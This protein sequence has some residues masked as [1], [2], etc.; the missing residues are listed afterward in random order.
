MN[1]KHKPLDRIWEKI[2]KSS[3]CWLWKAGKNQNGYGLIRANGKERLAHR[4]AWE[5]TN[6]PIPKGMCICHKC[7]NPAC[8]NPNHL[9]LGTQKDNIKDMDGKGRRGTNGVYGERVNTT[10]LTNNAV[11]EIRALHKNGHSCQCLSERFGVSHTQ[12]WRIVSGHQWKSIL[13]SK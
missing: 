13:I 7:D 5:L 8:I 4:L 11:L 2:D 12:I 1:N 3:G 9:F 10:K 6:G